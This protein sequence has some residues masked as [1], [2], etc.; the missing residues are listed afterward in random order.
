[1]SELELKDA[2]IQRLQTELETLK[3][4]HTLVVHTIVRV[5]KSVELW[6]LTENDNLAK[7]AI[8]GVQS[9]ITDSMLNPKR[10]QERFDFLKD[11]YPL[12]EKYKDIE[13]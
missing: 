5:L 10:L 8:K 1:M 11:I 2:E 3:N 7:K 12:C 9:V 4:E 13:V 6:P